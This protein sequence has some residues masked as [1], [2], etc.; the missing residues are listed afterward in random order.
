MLVVPQLGCDPKL[1]ARKPL[2]NIPDTILVVVDRGTVE[3]SVADL[4][5]AAHRLSDLVGRDA[6]RAE[7]AQPYGR[8]QSTRIQL[9][10]RDQRRVNRHGGNQF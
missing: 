5:S 8:H 2:E 1:L 4:Q 10:L 9:P 6:V 7:G 3:M